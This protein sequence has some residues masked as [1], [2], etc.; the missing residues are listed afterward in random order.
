MITYV[1]FCERGAPSKEAHQ[2]EALYLLMEMA[3]NFETLV[4]GEEVGFMDNMFTPAWENPSLDKLDVTQEL[5]WLHQRDVRLKKKAS[6]VQVN[7]SRQSVVTRVAL[8]W[9]VH[10]LRASTEESAARESLKVA[11]RLFGISLGIQVSRQ[12]LAPLSN[13]SA[14]G[15]EARHKDNRANRDHVLAWC[16]KNINDYPTME[17]AAMAVYEAREVSAEFKTI[18]KWM[19]EWRRQNPKI[20]A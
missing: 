15:A 7:C 16:D 10:A 2:L 8:S 9:A 20:K 14:S 18:R 5:E 12:T 19:T 6:L 17:K 13:F 1:D 3:W 4:L 11:N